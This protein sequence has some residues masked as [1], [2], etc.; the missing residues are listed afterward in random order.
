MDLKNRA[1]QNVIL[2]LGYFIGKLGRERVLLLHLKGVE[3]PGHIDYLK[4]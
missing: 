3:L 1:R 2:E 4:S